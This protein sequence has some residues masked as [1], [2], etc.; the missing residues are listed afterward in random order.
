MP[1]SQ[2]REA[3][4][5]AQARRVV[6]A[7]TLKGK[8]EAELQAAKLAT[9]REMHK[10]NVRDFDFRM[11]DDTYN[12]QLFRPSKERVSPQKL[13]V[14]VKDGTISVDDFLEVVS[15]NRELAGDLLGDRLGSVLER[16]TGGL[17]LIITPV[18]D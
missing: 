3:R 18:G 4:Y 14:L 16:Y 8:A 12:A 13:Y 15:V 9:A 11:E 1:Q 17:D 6:T 7:Q 10:V 5:I 2:L